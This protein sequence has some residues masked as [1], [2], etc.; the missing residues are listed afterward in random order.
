MN[1][2]VSK[3][4]VKIVGMSNAAYHGNKTFDSRSYLCQV[5][6]GGGEAQLWM[7]NGQSMFAGSS[8]TRTGD[9]FDRLL[10]GM[11]AG[12]LFDELVCVAPDGVLGANGSRNTKAYKEW[13]AEQTG[14]CCTEDQAW[15]YR[16]MTHNAFYN[17]AAKSLFDATTETQ[18]S[19]FWQEDNGHKLK[20]RPDAVTDDLWW[21]LKTTS[22]PWELLPKSVCSYGYAEQAWLYCRGAMEVGW[23][24][25]SM[26]FVF[27]QTIPPYQC[28]VFRLPAAFIEEAGQRL[29]SVMEEVRL[30]RSTGSYLPLDSGEIQELEIPRWA[31]KQEEVVVL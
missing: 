25:F 27:V 2:D 18:M 29:L 30:R 6:R 4:P 21:D 13:A 26:P 7:D 11:V 17:R 16:Q 24:Q 22:Q 10:T 28:R 8:A 31:R 3:G 20:V 5:A 9:E 12:Q 14:I 23:P 19:V 1:I 15:V